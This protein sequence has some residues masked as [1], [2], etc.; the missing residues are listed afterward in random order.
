MAGR[1]RDGGG[2]G[3]FD[4]VLSEKATFI[5]LYARTLKLFVCFRLCPMAQTGFDRRR[6]NGPEESSPPV[7]EHSDVQ[8]SSQWK[9]GDP[10]KGRKRDEIRP[11][12][13]YTFLRI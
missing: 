9:L 6:I 7:F 11:I 13:E 10:R 4:L 12:C 5:G 1:L 2:A 3:G 8:G